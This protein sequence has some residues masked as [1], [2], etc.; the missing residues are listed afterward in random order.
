[1]KILGNTEGAEKTNGSQ[2]HITT[3]AQLNSILATV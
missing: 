1:M 2:G 3:D